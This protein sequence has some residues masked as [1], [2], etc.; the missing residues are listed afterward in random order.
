MFV[1]SII[2]RLNNLLRHSMIGILLF[3]YHNIGESKSQ[4]A[5]TGCTG[6]SPSQTA[7]NIGK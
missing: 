4:G 2:I 7:M 5:A 3:F 1:I 6:A